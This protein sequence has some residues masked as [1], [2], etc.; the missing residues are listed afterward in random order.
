MTSADLDDWHQA[1]G[2]LVSAAAVAERAVSQLARALS[3]VNE[4]S[5]PYLLPLE[6]DALVRI[7][8]NLMPLHV[9]DRRLNDDVLEWTHQVRKLY[10]VRTAVVH[11]VWQ[12]T[13]ADSDEGM[14]PAW[15]NAGIADHPLTVA[16]LVRTTRRITDLCGDPL[17][18]LLRRVAELAP[19]LRIAGPAGRTDDGER[20]A[21]QA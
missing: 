6:L 12:D 15:S 13:D 8:R 1:V 19:A 7:I 10:A 2:R 21:G 9:R 20:S 14:H 11:T 4:R 5:A 17:E 18:Q 3:G 16:E